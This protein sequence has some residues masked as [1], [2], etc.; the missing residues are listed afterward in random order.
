VTPKY[1]NI[2]VKLSDHDG[3]AFMVLGLCLREVKAAGLAKDEMTAFREEA[4]KGDYDHLIRTALRW[5]ECE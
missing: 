4:M 2:R 5:F 3:N 1:P